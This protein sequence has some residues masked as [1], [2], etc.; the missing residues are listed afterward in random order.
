MGRMKLFVVGFSLL[1]LSAFVLLTEGDTA[2]QQVTGSG[3]APAAKQP[4]AV[5]Y[6]KLPLSFEANQV[7]T[8]ERVTFLS[9]GRGYTLFLTPTESGSLG[10]GEEAGRGSADASR[11]D[12]MKRRGLLLNPSQI[13]EHLL[14][15]IGGALREARHK[16]QRFDAK[17]INAT[18]RELRR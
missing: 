11:K 14:N 1:L 17:A 5:S 9:R 2:R 4:F 13:N 6:G 16:W 8:D 7:R 12:S 18:F 3:I 15:G 10:E